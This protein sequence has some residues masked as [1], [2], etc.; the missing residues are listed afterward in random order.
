MAAKRRKRILWTSAD[1]KL[2]K[3]HAGKTPVAQTAKKLKRS[4]A[5]VRFK[6]F[7]KRIRLARKRAA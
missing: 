7:T 4:E 3:Q 5:A 2:L 1:L 6:A